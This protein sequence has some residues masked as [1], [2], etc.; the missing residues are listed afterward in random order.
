MAKKHIVTLGGPPGSGKSTV[1]RLLAEKLDYASFS[2]G[3][4]A[5]S[6]AIEQGLTLEVFNEL[7]A[8]DG[9]LDEKIDHEQQRIEAEGDRYI[10][11]A[12]LG[13]Y[14]VPSSFKVYLDITP[15][16]SAH[17]IFNDRDATLR[18]ASGDTMATY[19][20]ALERTKKRTEN[21]LARYK[22]HYGINPYDTTQYDLVIDS[23]SKQPAEIAEEILT[24]YNRWL[25]A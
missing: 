7:V 17:R 5:R 22:E 21:H 13:F 18:K 16:E 11:D 4:F 6:I 3:N 25:E 19:E 14:F 23:T 15:E 10:I 12:H 9:S 1:G 2:T 20:E 24:A 8:E